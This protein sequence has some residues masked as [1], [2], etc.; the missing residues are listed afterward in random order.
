MESES[1]HDDRSAWGDCPQ[2]ALVKM[3]ERLSTERRHERRRPLMRVGAVLLIAVAC[4]IGGS[5]LINN[6]QDSTVDGLTCTQC[7][8]YM[9][10]HHDG[11]LVA[12]LS[13]QVQAHLDGCP[14][15]REHY[16]INFSADGG[17]AASGLAIHRKPRPADKMPQGVDDRAE[18]ATWVL[19][20]GSVV[21]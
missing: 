9:P 6:R 7:V 1:K 15:C 11:T 14:H 19:A 13:Q 5:W 18:P 8:E 21:R 16:E 3:V 2:D 4:G 17:E 12:P 20:T 10:A